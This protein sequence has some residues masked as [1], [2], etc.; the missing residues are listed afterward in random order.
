MGM[1][2]HPRLTTLYLNALTRQGD[3]AP[4]VNV[5]TAQI[6]GS[7]VQPYWGFCGGK[8]T[9]TDPWAA[10]L[11]DPAVGPLYGGVFQYVQFDPLMTLPAV[12]GAVAF[13]VNVNGPNGELGYRV[14]TTYNATTAVKPAGIILNPDLPGN[15]DFIQIGGIAMGQF[16]AAGT[17]GNPVSVLPTTGAPSVLTGAGTVGPTMVGVS[18]FTAPATG[19]M[20]PV[21]MNIISGWNQ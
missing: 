1:N 10:A 15:W 6:S 12:R 21:E 3:P 13:W 18:V 9:V 19:V 17:L 14:T 2:Q 20:S 11:A 4:G 16:S 5:S 8:L 7:I